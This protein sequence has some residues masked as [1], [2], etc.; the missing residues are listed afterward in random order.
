[1]NLINADCLEAMKDIPDG[2]VDITITSP[3]YNL[4]KR[5]SGGG[6]SKTSYA[7]W[8]PDEMPEVEYQE[9]QQ[10]VLSECLRITKGS[11]FYNHRVRYAWHSRNKHRTPSNIYHPWD[12]VSA[13]PIWSEI[14]WFRRGCTGHANRRFRIADER[15]YQIGKPHFFKDNG[16]LSVWEIVPDRNDKHPCSFPLEL[17]SR[18][19]KTFCPLGGTVFDPFMGSGTTGVAAKNLDRN[20]IGIEMDAEYFKIA[21]KRIENA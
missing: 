20:F 21:Q 15:I 7:G 13:F 19:I 14:I 3:P 11:V 5:A 2:S 10:K 1:M 6:N 9:W 17:P 8:Y 18:C 4:A 12:I 16:F